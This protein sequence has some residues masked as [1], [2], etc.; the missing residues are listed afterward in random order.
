MIGRACRSGGEA[1]RVVAIVKTWGP[2]GIGGPVLRRLVCDG[3]LNGRD[4]AVPA[5]VVT[6]EGHYEARAGRKPHK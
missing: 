2:N 4:V 5:L 1:S 6:S 3:I